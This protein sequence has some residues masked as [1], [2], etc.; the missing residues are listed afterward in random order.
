MTTIPSSSPG[1]PELS[2]LPPLH[3]NSG[4]PRSSSSATPPTEGTPHSSGA[5]GSSAR[6]SRSIPENQ[7]T[8]ASRSVSAVSTKL[9]GDLALADFK[10]ETVSIQAKSSSAWETVAARLDATSTCASVT[11]T[12]EIGGGGGLA[13]SG[14]HR[15]N[16]SVEGRRKHSGD[17]E[18][19]SASAVH[20]GNSCWRRNLSGALQRS[21]RRGELVKQ[22]RHLASELQ[23][24]IGPLR[25][26][27]TLPIRRFWLRR[28][29]SWA[30]LQRS[31]PRLL[32]SQRPT[33]G[34]SPR[35]QSNAIRPY[36]YQQDSST[37]PT[38]PRREAYGS[39]DP[40]QHA[41]AHSPP[42]QAL[43]SRVGPP[44]PHGPARPPPNAPCLLAPAAPV[45]PHPR[46]ISASF[47][48]RSSGGSTS[49]S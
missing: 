30:G 3:T 13:G 36:L 41:N 28:N 29:A 17:Q 2:V 9:V 7:L 37:P 11:S 32:A 40:S 34:P 47:S 43:T 22:G 16:A 14:R 25:R 15:G 1:A 33:A 21:P 46:P 45:A 10:K 23:I 49:P 39:S 19:D 35:P 4:H 8:A 44:Q 6:S 42:P 18:G 20:A 24:R 38:S 5:T 48:S 12:R 31:R 26:G 27:E